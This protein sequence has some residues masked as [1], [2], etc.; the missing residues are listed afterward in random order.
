MKL[1]LIPLL[2]KYGVDIIIAGHE[3]WLEYSNQEYAHQWRYL[4]VEYDPVVNNCTDKEIFTTE[5]R[6]IHQTYGERFHQFTVGTAGAVWVDLVCPVKDMDVNLVYRSAT[7][8]GTMS[9]EVT[10]DLL[11]ASFLNADVTIPYK[12][13]IR[14]LKSSE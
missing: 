11:K 8:T 4:D 13:Y 5:T 7:Q 2:R 1:S 6:E 10:T 14:K 9:V 12:I 3:N